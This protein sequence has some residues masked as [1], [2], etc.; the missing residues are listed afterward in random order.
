MLAGLFEIALLLVG[1]ALGLE[2]VVASDLADRFLD[3][4]LAMGL[5]RDTWAS[6]VGPRAGT[7]RDRRQG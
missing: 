1:L 4:A 7:A 5:G 6:D 3:L 2:L